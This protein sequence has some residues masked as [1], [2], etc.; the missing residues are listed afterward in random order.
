MCVSGIKLENIQPFTIALTETLVVAVAKNGV[1][2]W[3]YNKMSGKGGGK[4]EQGI[5]HDKVFHIDDESTS[6]HPDL[7]GHV[8]KV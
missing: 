2:L 8:L 1:M 4:N 7:A 5:R 6:A 3:K